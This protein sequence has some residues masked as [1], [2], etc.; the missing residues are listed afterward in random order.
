MAAPYVFPSIFSIGGVPLIDFVGFITSGEGAFLIECLP[1]VRIM[2][3]NFA[4]TNEV[5]MIILNLKVVNLLRRARRSR[6]KLNRRPRSRDYA[7][8]DAQL[9]RFNKPAPDD[10]E[11]MLARR[12]YSFAVIE[13]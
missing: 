3:P 5:S 11:R 13:G 4:L 7:A 10:I 2:H 1:A 6:N 9:A 12:L 8:A